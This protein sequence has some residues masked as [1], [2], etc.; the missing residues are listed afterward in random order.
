MHCSDPEINP[1]IVKFKFI[2]FIIISPGIDK[3]QMIKILN[4]KYFNLKINL[5]GFNFTKQ[6][7][8][9]KKEIT[10]PLL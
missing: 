1:S 3:G 9:N 5:I 7:I 8:N 4:K 10:N 2:T 6:Q